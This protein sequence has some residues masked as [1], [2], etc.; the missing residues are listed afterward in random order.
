[1]I[2]RNR[3][4]RWVRGKRASTVDRAV[5]FSP[6][7]E[8]PP[9]VL[10]LSMVCMQLVLVILQ[11]KP[12]KKVDGAPWQYLVGGGDLLAEV[13]ALMAATAASGNGWTWW[14]CEH[15]TVSFVF[16]QNFSDLPKFMV[17]HVKYCFPRKAR[18]EKTVACGL[19]GAKKG[20]L[21]PCWLKR[22]GNLARI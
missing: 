13:K 7:A 10:L 6:M 2:H 1:M 3:F 8:E 17:F 11:H 4:G 16:W 21:R 19:G 12:V 9:H 22:Y 5:F 15:I 18:A 20:P 14:I